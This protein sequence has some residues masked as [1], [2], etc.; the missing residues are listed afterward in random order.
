MTAEELDVK[1][2]RFPKNLWMVYETEKP[3]GYFAF[4]VL[5]AALIKF[6]EMGSIFQLPGYLSEGHSF[7]WEVIGV[8][9]SNFK[10]VIRA[11]SEEEAIT[12]MDM[13]GVE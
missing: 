10:A 6:S 1:E 13:Y 11:T 3:G 2:L 9:D 5:A 7:E 8:T 12:K 4:P